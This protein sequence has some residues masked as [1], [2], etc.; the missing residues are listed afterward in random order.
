MR[1]TVLQK[2]YSIDPFVMRHR[3]ITGLMMKTELKQTEWKIK[4]SEW[5]FLG[6]DTSGDGNN[7]ASFAKMFD[8]FANLLIVFAS[9]S[10]FSDVS[11]PVWTCLDLFGFVSMH[12]DASGCIRMRSDAFGHF[13]RISKNKPKI[14][15]SAYF[16]MFSR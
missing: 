3:Q 16:E 11:R 15:V 6:G 5:T 8:D 7:F 14:L 13:R 2:Y 9:F 12:L 10:T 1:R 4:W